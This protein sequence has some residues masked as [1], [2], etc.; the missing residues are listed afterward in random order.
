MTRDR[1]VFG[2]I[3]AEPDDEVDCAEEAVVILGVFAAAGGAGGGLFA[4][5]FR[6]STGFGGGE[7]TTAAAVGLA[8]A[9]GTLGAGAATG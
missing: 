5:D 2:D 6:A 7:A 4:G 1:L 3:T 8:G 9:F